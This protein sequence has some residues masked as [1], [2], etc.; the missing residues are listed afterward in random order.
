MTPHSYS[1][2]FF[3]FDKF[4]SNYH[5]LKSPAVGWLKPGK[6]AQLQKILEYLRFFA[7]AYTVVYTYDRVHF[8]WGR[9]R[10]RV[11]IDGYKDMYH[12]V[13]QGDTNIALSVG[14]SFRS[15]FDP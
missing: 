6:P 10:L 15:Y 14:G 2:L 7:V 12:N 4:P 11:A 3:N 5:H 1:G 9:V 8:A 13:I